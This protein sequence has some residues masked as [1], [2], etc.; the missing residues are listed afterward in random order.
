MAEPDL[1]KIIE[2][3]MKNPELISQIKELSAKDS[4][5]SAAQP[6]SEEHEGTEILTEEISDSGES[7]QPTAY[8]ATEGIP[9]NSAD[10]GIRSRRNELLR[11]LKPYVSNERGKAIES[12][13]TIAD[14]LDMMRSK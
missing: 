5:E 2:L 13:M 6:P 3:I 7:S 9:P 4:D 12:M 8:T 10:S 1:G 11:A 14:I